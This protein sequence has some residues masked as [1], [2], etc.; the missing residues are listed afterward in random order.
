MILIRLR[1]A[2]VSDKENIHKLDVH[3]AIDAEI[4]FPR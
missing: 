2:S 4:Q 3:T 1:T